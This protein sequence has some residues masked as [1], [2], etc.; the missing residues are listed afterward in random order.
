M[1]LG[2]VLHS[3]VAIS[4]GMGM[5]LLERMMGRDSYQRDENKFADH[6]NYD[7][8]LVSK[9]SCFMHHTNYT[10]AHSS[11]SLTHSLT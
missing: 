11:Y 5:S 7:P 4:Y 3:S 8:L 9:T 1:Q 2:P 10:C 6:G